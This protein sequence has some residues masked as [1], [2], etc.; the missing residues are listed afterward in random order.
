MLSLIPILIYAPV[1]TASEPSTESA[2]TF[3][4]R[5]SYYMLAEA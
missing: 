1:V 4:R 5:S 3:G 2:S